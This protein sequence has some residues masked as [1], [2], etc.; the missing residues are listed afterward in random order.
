MELNVSIIAAFRL[1]FW[2]LLD[3]PLPPSLAKRFLIV[4]FTMYSMW[5]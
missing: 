2:E 1:L 4:C 5:S 3:P